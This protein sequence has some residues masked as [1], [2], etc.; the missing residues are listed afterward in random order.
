M[1]LSGGVSSGMSRSPTCKGSLHST[2]R[3]FE[4]DPELRFDSCFWV[5]TLRVHRPAGGD[6]PSQQGLGRTLQGRREQSDQRESQRGE[7]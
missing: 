4:K 3:A 5:K 6:R 2:E 1:G 7:S